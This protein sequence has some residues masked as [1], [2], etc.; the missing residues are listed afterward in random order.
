MYGTGTSS[1]VPYQHVTLGGGN[2]K[3]EANDA[4][5]QASRIALSLVGKNFFEKILNQKNVNL[6]FPHFL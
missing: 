2:E 3:N 4:L 1:H 5:P 6:F